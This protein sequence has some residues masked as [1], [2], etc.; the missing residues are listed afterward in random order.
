MKI[1]VRGFHFDESY[2]EMSRDSPVEM[3]YDLR[4]DGDV[5]LDSVHETRDKVSSLASFENEQP[6]P[7][8]NNVL[9]LIF[10]N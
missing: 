10:F 7:L 1:E 2:D 6:D 8:S 9:R 4:N 3:L 5:V